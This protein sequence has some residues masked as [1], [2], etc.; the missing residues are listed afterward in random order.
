MHAALLRPRCPLLRAAPSVDATTPPGRKASGRAE[1]AVLARNLTPERVPPAA[2]QLA[3][4]EVLVPSAKR[5]SD[6]VRCVGYATTVITTPLSVHKFAE[7]PP[8]TLTGS[9][10][11]NLV[12]DVRSDSHDAQNGLSEVAV[13]P[14]LLPV[15]PLA[16][17][18]AAY[19]RRAHDCASRQQSAVYIAYDGNRPLRA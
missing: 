1:G 18:R 9:T 19:R 2:H 10:L 16:P 11:R 4:D 8:L 12:L 15:S 17:A 6:V 14:G 3:V 13:F 7:F 5:L